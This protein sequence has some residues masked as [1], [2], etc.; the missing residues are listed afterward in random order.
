MSAFQK[1]LRAVSRTKC[2]RRSNLTEKNYAQVVQAWEAMARGSVSTFDNLYLHDSY[3][4]IERKVLLALSPEVTESLNPELSALHFL[5][6]L[7]D[8][9]VLHVDHVSLHDRLTLKIA[10]RDSTMS[11]SLRN[12]TSNTIFAFRELRKEAKELGAVEVDLYSFSV[13]P[14]QC[15]RANQ[16]DLLIPY[17]KHWG[18][19]E[20]A[21]ILRR[22]IL[23][24]GFETLTD[25]EPR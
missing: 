16:I 10:A 4:D 25:F 24:Q 2:P 19:M 23:R 6:T 13:D 21:E 14:E 15:R 7:S 1:Y 18:A 11:L 9:D 8:L 17:G 3:L 22:E 5:E 20:R 12:Q